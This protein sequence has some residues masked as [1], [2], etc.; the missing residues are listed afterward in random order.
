MRFVLT[1]LFGIGKLVVLSERF[2]IVEKLAIHDHSLFIENP[3]MVVDK[4][5][6]FAG[7]IGHCLNRLDYRTLKWCWWRRG[8]YRR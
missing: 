4:R 6:L 5:F 8:H 1:G 3:V 7:D 2:V